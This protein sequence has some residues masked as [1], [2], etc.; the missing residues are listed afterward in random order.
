MA[1]CEWTDDINHKGPR[2]GAPVYQGR[3]YCE[4]HIWRIYQKGTGLGRRKKDERTAN[5]MRGVSSELNRI[6][7]CE[8]DELRF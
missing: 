1:G 6:A 3:G 7:E 2:C 4:Q 8:V 5:V